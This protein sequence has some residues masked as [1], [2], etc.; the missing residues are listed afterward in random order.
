[1]LAQRI[2][3]LAI[4]RIFADQPQSTDNWGDDEVDPSGIVRVGRGRQ[5]AVVGSART[6]VAAD[7]IGE[8]ALVKDR[9]FAKRPD[10]P[11]CGGYGRPQERVVT[12]LPVGVVPR[13]AE[14][15]ASGIILNLDIAGDGSLHRMADVVD[16]DAVAVVPS[17]HVELI[18]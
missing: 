7:G 3:A 12:A 9:R 11:L 13:D 8:S 2:R 10:L 18:E 1:M 15:P 6:V 5:L 17:P 14:F 4:D 16:L